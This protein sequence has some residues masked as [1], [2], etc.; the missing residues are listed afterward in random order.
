MCRW[1]GG[2]RSRWV[3]LEGERLESA[4]AKLPFM[5]GLDFERWCEE[6]RFW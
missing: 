3:G 1:W 5:C 2:R 6:L 4:L